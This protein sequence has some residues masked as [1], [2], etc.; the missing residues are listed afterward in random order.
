MI[1]S[2]ALR[3]DWT[4]VTVGLMVLFFVFGVWPLGLAMLAYILCG[5]RIPEVRNHFGAQKRAWSGKGRCG[6]RVHQRS[7]NVAF[8][9]YRARELKRLEE[10]RN[11]LD[12]ELREFETFM[13]D[14]RRA[15]DEEEFERFRRNRNGNAGNNGD[16]GTAGAAGATIN[17]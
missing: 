1:S 11:R 14:L 12:E 6:P 2:Q 8:D 16:T 5:D 3:P 4:P 13:A 10:E 17:L 9:D 7:G 15:R